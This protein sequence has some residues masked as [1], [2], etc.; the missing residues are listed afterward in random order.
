[1]NAAESQR[2]LQHLRRLAGDLSGTLSDGELLQRYLKC[3]DQAAFTALVR[4]HGPMVFSVCQ[5]VL[6]QRDDAEDAFQAAFLILAQKAGSVRRHEGLGGW[7]QSVAYHVALRARARKARR[8]IQ[9]ANA[10]PAPPVPSACDD[11]SWG[12][13]RTILHAELAALPEKFRAPLV[14]CYLEGLTQEEAAHRLGCTASTIKGRL[15]RGRE[16]LRRRLERRGVA[17]T[18]ALAAALTGQTLAESCMQTLCPFTLETAT[19]S[20][21]AIARCFGPALASMKWKMVAVVFFSVGLAAGGVGMLSLKPSE[22]ESTTVSVDSPVTEHPA[23]RTDLYGDPLPEGAIARMGSIQLR[24]AGQSDF[25]V[26]PDSKTILTTGG[27]VAR[28]WDMASG[29]L[30]REVKLQGPL[31]PGRT[32][33]PSP[34]GKIL[35]GLDQKKIVF[36]DIDSGKQIKTL[37]APEENWANLYFSHDS[38]T[39]ILATWKPQVILCDW[40]KGNERRIALPVRKVGFDSTFHTRVSPDGKLL[41]GVGGWG[42]PLCV[43]ELA[44]GREIHRFLCNASTSTFSPDSTRLI[45]SSMENDKKARETVIRVFDMANGKE[46]KQYPLGHEYSYFSL[47]CAPDGKTLLCGF[48]DRSCLLDLATGRVLHSLTGRP[49]WTAFTPDGKTLIANMGQQIRMWDAATGKVLGDRVGEF[50]W[51]PVLAVSPDGRLLAEADWLDQHV[52][53][54]DTNSGRLLRQLSLKGENRY[55]RNLFFSADGKTLVACQFKGFLEFWDAASGKEQRTV[56]L[57]DPGWRNTDFVYFFQLHLSP[58]GKHLSTLERVIIPKEASRLAYW[59][60]ETGKILSQHSLPPESRTCAWSDDGT[61]VALPLSEGLTQMDVESGAIRYRIR[62]TRNGGPLAASPDGR[63]LAALRAESSKDEAAIGIWESATGKEVANVWSVPAAHLALMPD[64]RHLVVADRNYLRVW[65]LATGKE[66]R[67]W[68]LPERNTS[69][70]N[71]PVVTRLLLS[72]DGRRAF[73]ALNDGTALVWD[74]QSALRHPRP[75]AGRPNEKELTDWWADLAG[76]DAARA[77][78]AIW[79]LTETPEATISFVRQRVKP[80]KAAD[81]QMIRRHIAELGSDEFATR[82]KAFEQL[83]KLGPSAEPALRHAL[84][85]KPTLEAR[86]RMQHLLEKIDQQPPV[87]ETLRLMRT[88]QVLENVGTEGRQLLRELA[89]GAAEAWLTRE[90]KAALSRLNRRAW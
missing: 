79:R 81:F 9:E 3:R 56:Q 40:E 31:T 86:R 38:K 19:T 45:V 1:M 36:W 32:A 12:E 74:L 14:L 50:G 54:W 72:P 60:M 13:L 11:L 61:K 76:E 77:Y 75:L 66:Q 5:S 62:G 8:Q 65:D 73:T 6:R 88:L 39:F 24:H 41:A 70:G 58:D 21:A 10:A 15:Q 90:A 57:Q 48:S 37:P 83:A 71:D 49:I 33:T 29:R 35:A 64:N 67:R 18:A 25:V 17:L 63:L 28:F 2:L 23:P 80:A 42:E 69:P 43:Y 82:E 87:G 52:S 59:D 22:G 55:V 44:T 20:A 27:R 78:A 51:Q 4:R 7:L 46:V 16:K 26:L 84:E 89:G 85:Q 30:V 68:P 53:L 34:D 47:A